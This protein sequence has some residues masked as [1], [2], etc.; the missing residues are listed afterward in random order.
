MA[1]ATKAWRIELEYVGSRDYI[2]GADLFRWFEKLCVEHLDPASRPA[3][4]RSFRLHREIARD[5]AWSVDEPV[6][7]PA[8]EID[9]ADASGRA[10]RAAF[11]DDGETIRRRGPDREPRLLSNEPDGEFGGRATIAAPPRT[12]ELLFAIVEANKANHVAAL[13]AR[14]LRHDKLRFLYLEDLAVVA[15]APARRDV[16]DFRHLR[17]RTV[18]DRACTLVSVAT[19]SA[20]RPIK[21]CFSYPL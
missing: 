17:T 1:G 9:F 18:G 4:V 8:A 13:K 19:P 3:H 14:G 12:S 16:L 7:A 11:L 15:A 10:R 21:I 5:G 20:A 6:E 2:A